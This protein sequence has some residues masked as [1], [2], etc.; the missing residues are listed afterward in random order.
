[1]YEPEIL[2]IENVVMYEDSVDDANLPTEDKDVLNGSEPESI[3]GAQER[4]KEGTEPL[5]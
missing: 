2:E 1:M 3:G 5:Q 4:P